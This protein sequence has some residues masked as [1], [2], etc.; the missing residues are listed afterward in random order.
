QLI[1]IHGLF[2][3]HVS[4]AA[5]IAKQRGIPYWIVPHGALD[6]YVFT[7][8]AAQKR[9]WMSLVG[10]PVLRHADRVIVAT[11][12]ERVKAQ[13]YLQGCRVET[14]YWPV[15]VRPH[16]ST[17]SARARVRE[18]LGI[19]ETDRA[20]LFLGRLDPMKRV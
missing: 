18:R 1:L 12:R 19:P 7:Y 13:P 6:P 11:E 4:W 3:S 10:G 17:S 5:G 20:L 14:V 2:R 15:Q 16:D 9:V 8:R